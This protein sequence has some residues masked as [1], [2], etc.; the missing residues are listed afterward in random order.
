MEAIIK[1]G[2]PVIYIPPHG[3]INNSKYHEHGIVKSL[4]EHYVFV[5]YILHGIPQSTAKATR[6]ED[7]Y[8]Q[9]GEQI[10]NIQ[11]T[12]KKIKEHEPR[13]NNNDT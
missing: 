9:D 12:Y 13:F 2:D 1:I 7:L 10:M 5:T 8:Y 6:Y 4:N 11:K 3:D